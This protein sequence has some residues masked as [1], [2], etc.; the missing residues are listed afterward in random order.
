MGALNTD[1]VREPPNTG[2]RIPCR[3]PPVVSFGPSFPTLALTQ[4]SLAPYSPRCSR[5]LPRPTL[6]LPNSTLVTRC[7]LW[8]LAGG[9][10]GYVPGCYC[11]DLLR[12]LKNATLASPD[13]QPLLAC[14]VQQED[15]TQRSFGSVHAFTQDCE[16]YIPPYPPKVS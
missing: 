15:K 9:T 7:W 13:P 6:L 8:L 10:S 3:Q 1:A 11:W 4:G 14:P 16:F 12:P 5:M 2:A